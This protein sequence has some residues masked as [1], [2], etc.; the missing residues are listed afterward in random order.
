MDYQLKVNAQSCLEKLKLY[1]IK[2]SLLYLYLVQFLKLQR[3]TNN[4]VK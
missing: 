3:L 2:T 4:L 1:K